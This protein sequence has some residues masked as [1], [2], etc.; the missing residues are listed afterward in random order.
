MKSANKFGAA[1]LAILTLAPQMFG[2]ALSGD[3]RAAI[4]Q[5]VQ[6]LIVVDY[7]AMQNS[8]VAMQLKARVLPPELKGLEEALKKS[9]LNENHDVDVLAFA[10]FRVKPGSE[11]TRIIGIA[12]G[13]FQM[14]EILL[15]LKKK[16][17]KPE[18]VRTN[19]LFPMGDTGMRIC[20]LNSSAFVFGAD[21]AV[22]LALDARDGISSSMLSNQT[23]T[24]LASPV[25]NDAVWS[26]LDAK[27]TQFMMR[28]LLSEAPSVTDF[29]VVKKQLQGSRYSMN[30]ANGVEFNLDV[31]TPDRFS[32]ATMSTL[33]NAALLYKKA[34]GTDTEKAA[35][36][37]TNI[38]ADSG[39][40]KV[41]YESSDNQFA[42]LLS[43][44]LF[45]SVVH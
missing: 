22:K 42:S 3:A 9:G 41:R 16:G 25:Q 24:D 43:S 23:M 14:R 7:R 11:N 28:Q 26:V 1:A 37:A 34:T 30:F 21:D 31:V 18:M 35:L 40:L 13:Q 33:L 19:K 12:Q 45:Q 15:G 27:G 32:A 38:A 44:S 39:T 17:I 2:A 29:D 4:P 36:T 20:F 6:Q 5:D 8:P 10:S